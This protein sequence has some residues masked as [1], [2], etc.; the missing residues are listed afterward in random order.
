MSF[1]YGKIVQHPMNVLYT[2]IFSSYLYNKLK[3]ESMYKSFIELNSLKK[4]KTCVEFIACTEMDRV[5]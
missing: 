1:L 3:Y 2:M 4:K 5:N